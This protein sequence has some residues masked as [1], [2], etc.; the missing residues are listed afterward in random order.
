GRLLGVHDPVGRRRLVA[1]QSELRPLLVVADVGLE[2]AARAGVALPPGIG[3]LVLVVLGV[4]DVL[5][6]RLPD[7]AGAHALPMPQVEALAGR[8][9]VLVPEGLPLPHVAGRQAA[10]LLEGRRADGPD[11]GQ[12]VLVVL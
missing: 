5:V 3:R 12:L 6:V 9:R 4:V 10:L 1:R 8:A 7:G 2:A 11:D